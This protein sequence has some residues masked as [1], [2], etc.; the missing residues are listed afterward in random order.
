MFLV[1]AGSTRFQI[2]RVSKVDAA[3][4]GVESEWSWRAGGGILDRSLKGE[5]DRRPG[6][7][8]VEEESKEDRKGRER[9]AREP[10][11]SE[12]LDGPVNP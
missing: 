3:R 8:G 7:A 5:Q 9:Y 4:L 2:G 6:I 1:K 12:S 10:S 11:M